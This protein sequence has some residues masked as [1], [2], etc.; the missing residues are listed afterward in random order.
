MCE[1]VYSELFGVRQAQ[2]WRSAKG[3]KAVCKNTIVGTPRMEL[4]V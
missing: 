3:L 2:N 4:A 1:R